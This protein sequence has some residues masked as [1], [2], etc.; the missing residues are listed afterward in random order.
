[1][2]TLV[3]YKSQTGFTKKYAKWIAEGL[4]ADSI[5]VS[6]MNNDRLQNYDTIIYGGGLY[7]GGISG[8]KAITKN[9]D[10]IK[11]KRII[12]F[13]TGV[14]PGRD[15]ELEQVKKT[16]FTEYQERYIK[17]FYLRGGFNYQKLNVINK[18]LMSLLKLKLK[19]KKDL[20]PDERGM[21]AVYDKPIDFTN[22]K[23]ICKLI[24]YVTLDS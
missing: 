22:K 3:I 20:T 9:I 17:F 19:T 24:D 10:K 12:V 21:L 13:A 6:E 11:D 18:I 7:A 16:N 14:C 4:T 2:K 8:I 1:M 15:E 5:N 23:N